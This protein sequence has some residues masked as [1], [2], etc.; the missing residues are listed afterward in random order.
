[1]YI[2]AGFEGG[3][4][5]GDGS[6]V[7][8]ICQTS[9]LNVNPPFFSAISLASCTVVPSARGSENGRPTSTCLGKVSLKDV[10]LSRRERFLSLDFWSRDFDGA[11]FVLYRVR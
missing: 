4:D 5:S 11:G 1:M 9:S 7:C 3:E 8:W 10:G 6:A 2:R